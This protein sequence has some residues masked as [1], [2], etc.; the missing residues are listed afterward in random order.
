MVLL[1]AVFL[2]SQ[3]VGLRGK[4][5][6][7]ASLGVRGFVAATR[8]CCVSSMAL[9]VDLRSGFYTVVRELVVRLQSSGEDIERVIESISSPAQLG[10]PAQDDG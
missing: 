9:F 4:G 3:C 2:D 10:C 7:L 6:T 1:G 8:A 5:T